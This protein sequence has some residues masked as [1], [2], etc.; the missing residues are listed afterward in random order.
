MGA[1]GRT[2]VFVVYFTV[3]VAALAMSLLADELAERHLILQLWQRTERMN[4]KMACACRDYEEV[5][6]RMQTEPNVIARLVRVTLGPRTEQDEQ[7]VQPMSSERHLDVAEQVVSEMFPQRDELEELPGW[8]SRC[9][10]LAGRGALFAAGAGLILVSFACFGPR[11]DRAA[12]GRK[13]VHSGP[14]GGV[15]AEKV[16]GATSSSPSGDG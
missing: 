1:A 3:G 11:Y 7:V 9:S 5:V 15:S 4:E 12:G 8:L 14:A 13:D 2:V 6:G 16:I 10:S